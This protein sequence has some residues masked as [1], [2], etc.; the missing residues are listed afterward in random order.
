MARIR[1]VPK[2]I[3]RSPPPTGHAR[4][5][6]VPKPKPKATAKTAAAWYM[7]RARSAAGIRRNMMNQSDRHKSDFMKGKLYAYFYDAKW[8]KVLPIWDK[9]PL[10][11]PIERYPD[12]FL[13]LN[14]HYLSG[15]ERA[16]LLGKLLEFST[17]N[18]RSA[19]NRLQMSYALLDATKSLSTLAR[20]CIKRYLYAY[21]QSDFIEINADEW[22]EVIQLETAI[23]VTRK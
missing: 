6:K 15:P 8:K 7:G 22:D 23:W 2:P 3:P 11:F 9:F 20:P 13:G 4:I 12:G 18:K 10:V 19:T 21:M 16:S 14:L 5:R 1:K 17:D